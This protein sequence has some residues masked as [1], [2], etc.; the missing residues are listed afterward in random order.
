LKRCFPAAR[1]LVDPSQI[2][3][4][5]RTW[6]GGALGVKIRLRNGDFIT[7]DPAVAEAISATLNQPHA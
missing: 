6:A 7:V 4:V 5:D 1:V 2:V 3:A